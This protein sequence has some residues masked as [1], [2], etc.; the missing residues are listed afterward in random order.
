MTTARLAVMCRQWPQIV[1]LATTHRR[2][3]LNCRLRSRDDDAV[4]TRWQ[5]ALK[6]DHGWWTTARTSATNGG[7]T[8]EVPAM[9]TTDP[10]ASSVCRR[11]ELPQADV[12]NKSISA[13]YWRSAPGVTS[14]HGFTAR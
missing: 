7:V 4:A 2:H 11:R 5:L 13:A 10:S 1:A 9:A 8:P 14:S 3:E 12:P 6:G